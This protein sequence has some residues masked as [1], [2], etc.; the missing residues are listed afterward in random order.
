MEGGRRSETRGKDI[1]L[2][3]CFVMHG[4]L[5]VL[6]QR[7]AAWRCGVGINTMS[8]FLRQ[9]LL[10]LTHNRFDFFFRVDMSLVTSL[11]R[12]QQDRRLDAA[13]V[14]PRDNL[15]VA[16]RPGIFEGDEVHLTFIKVLLQF[17]G[18]GVEEADEASGA[19][20]LDRYVNGSHR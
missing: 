3:A 7:S 14:G 16:R 4:R 19:A 10:Q 2:K 11:L 13:T 18:G 5:S 1:L 20:E 6:R 12:M 17:R 15:K 9:Q 8:A